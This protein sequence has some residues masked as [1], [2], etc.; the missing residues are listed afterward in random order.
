LA[1][2]RVAGKYT[3]S[4]QDIRPRR[5]ILFLALRCG[6]AIHPDFYSDETPYLLTGV[7]FPG[8]KNPM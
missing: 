8:Q 2:F 3:T 5:P 1:H 6:I 4:P 7:E